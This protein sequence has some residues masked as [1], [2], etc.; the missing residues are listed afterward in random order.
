MKKPIDQDNYYKFEKEEEDLVHST[1]TLDDMIQYEED[2][3]RRMAVMGIKVKDNPKVYRRKRT[4]KETIKWINEEFGEKVI[5]KG[6][7]KD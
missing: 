6:E 2:K 5:W 4:V 3:K 1:G 7:K